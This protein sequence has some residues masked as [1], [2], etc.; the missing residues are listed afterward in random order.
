VDADPPRFSA[1]ARDARIATGIT[2]ADST[3]YDCRGNVQRL[4]SALIALVKGARRD[5]MDALTAPR[6]EKGI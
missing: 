4:D 2:K 5:G 1:L 3:V 6:N